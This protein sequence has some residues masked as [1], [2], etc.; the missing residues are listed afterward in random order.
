LPAVET[1][2]KNRKAEAIHAS[3]QVLGPG[4]FSLFSVSLD[5]D[6]AG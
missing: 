3:L 4:Q 6:I 5:F 2:G 1:T